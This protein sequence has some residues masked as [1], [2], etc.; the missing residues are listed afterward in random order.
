MNSSGRSKVGDG[1]PDVDN[2]SYSGLAFVS[3]IVFAGLV[4]I[5]ALDVDH[6]PKYLFGLTQNGR[7]FHSVPVFLFCS[8]IATAL[9]FGWIL[10]TRMIY[11]QVLVQKE[12][13]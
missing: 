4:F 1:M 11:M 9:V 6:I 2:D 10:H 7:L 12:C 5:C 8:F 3:R 13:E